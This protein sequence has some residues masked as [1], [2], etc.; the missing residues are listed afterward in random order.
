MKFET[1][2]R[3]VPF[4][5]GWKREYYDGKVH[6]RPS[7]VTIDYSLKLTQR[8]ERPTHGLRMCEATDRAQLIDAFIDSFCYAPEYAC[9][10]MKS[11]RKKAAEYVDGYFGSVRGERSPCSTVLEIEG[12]IVAAALVKLRPTLPPLLDCLFVRPACFRRGYATIVAARAVNRLVAHGQPILRSGAMLAN[13]ASIAWH[14]SFGFLERPEYFL[15]QSR[16]FNAIHERGRLEKCNLATAEQLAEWDAK[17]ASLK[18]EF[19]RLSLA[20]D[21]SNKPLTAEVANHAEKAK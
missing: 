16:Y 4:R 3:T 11:Y 19:E 8:P 6:L 7:W 5:P 18:D 10:S 15:A 9:D 20:E 1:F 12:Q 13:E 14:R 17:I 21:R 2:E